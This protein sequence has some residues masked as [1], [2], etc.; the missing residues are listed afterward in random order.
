MILKYLSGGEKAR[1]VL[2]GILA[3]PK[4][5]LVL[6]EPTNHLD[7]RSREI[8]LDALKSYDGT[9]L[10]VSHDRHFLRELTNR[11]WEVDKGVIRQFPGTYKEWLE[12]K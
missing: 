2:A 8:L 11:V 3:T 6:D 12:R 1:L 9:V 4:N 7:M 5:L 10:L